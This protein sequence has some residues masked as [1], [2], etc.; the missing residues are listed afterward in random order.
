MKS[1]NIT[2]EPKQRRSIEK[3]QKIME[4]GM[5]LFFSKGYH[6]TNTAEI[7]KEA[8]VSTGI[9]YRYYKDKHDILMEG[10]PVFIHKIQDKMLDSLNGEVTNASSFQSF[11]DQLLDQ[12][13]EFHYTCKEMHE[14][15]QSL[16]CTDPAIAAYFIE[17]EQD[18]TKT[19]IEM[20]EHI[21]VNLDH[22]YERVH[23]VYNIIEDFCHETAFHD[24]PEMNTAFYKQLVIEQT[25]QILMQN[26]NK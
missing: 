11:L 23:M 24:H 25:M 26:T 12:L 1:D 18:I 13:L 2:M 21:G 10:L 20:V 4:A 5:Q 22:P 15:I 8:G 16:I 14:Q 7:A 6:N 3:K 17:W 9:V 19:V